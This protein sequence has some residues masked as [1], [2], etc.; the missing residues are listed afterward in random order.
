MQYSMLAVLRSE[1]SSAHRR[2]GK[3][4]T[5]RRMTGKKRIMVA[6]AAFLLILLAADRLWIGI[7]TSPKSQL[8]DPIYA[9]RYKAK[10]VLIKKDRSSFRLLFVG[11]S[12]FQQFDQPEPKIG[13]FSDQDVWRHYYYEVVQELH[14]HL[15]GAHILLLGIL[16]L[17]G[18]ETSLIR[19]VD[20]KLKA[21]KIRTINDQLSVQFGRGTVPYVTYVDLTSLFL[22]NGQVDTSLLADR[23]HPTPQGKALMAAAIEPEVS[24]ILGDISKGSTVTHSRDCDGSSICACEESR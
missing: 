7:P 22:R 8:G 3:R 19:Y 15:P 12:I 13:E 20:Y 14:S 2:K 9:S 10:E 23:V 21:Y 18:H 24:R 5:P 16:P 1:S 17:R 4:E 11:D 6:L